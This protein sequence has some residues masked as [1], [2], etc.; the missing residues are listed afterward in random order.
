MP[1]TTRVLVIHP[2]GETYAS[3]NRAESLVEADRAYWRDLSKTVLVILSLSDDTPNDG[4]EYGGKKSYNRRDT[5]EA[6]DLRNRA[7][8]RVP[9][10]ERDRTLIPVRQAG[11]A[12]VMQLKPKT[13]RRTGGAHTPRRMNLYRPKDAQAVSVRANNDNPQGF[14]LESRSRD[15]GDGDRD[16]IY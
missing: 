9:I 5:A 11:G 7:I 14:C 8:I 6:C 13:D 2:N 10:E 12:K 4:Y 3:R 16:R 1:H 15:L